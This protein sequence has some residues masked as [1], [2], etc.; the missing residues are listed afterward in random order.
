MTEDLITSEMLEGLP[1]PVQR[2]LTYSGV[3]GKPRIK[4]VRILF[5][6]RF[7]RGMDQPWMPMTADQVY[8]T[9]PP[10]FVWKARFK[11]AGLPLM[12][13]RDTYKDGEGYMFARLAWL[14][15]IFDVRGEKLTQGTMLRYLQEMMWFP[16]AYLEPYITWKAVDD[17]C[18][19]VTF[20]DHGKS[21]SGRMYFD[22]QGQVTDFVTER[23]REVNGNFV[24]N[25]W[26]TPVDTYGRLAGLNLPARGK[27]VWKL[28][29]GDLSYAE[30]EIRD[31][32]YNPGS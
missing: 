19:E 30:L 32:I 26:S 11:V 21:V 6:G 29:E 31:V 16:A 15:P 12:H 25:T 8:T 7:R 9:N 20:T 10:G 14:I 4:T 18:A 23:Y 22:A 27:A 13:A 1:A 28:P 17:N 3:L 24:L 5:S 2:Y